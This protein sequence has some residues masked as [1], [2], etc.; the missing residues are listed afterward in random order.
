MSLEGGLVGCQIGVD[1]YK[2]GLLR[3][4]HGKEG[5]LEGTWAAGLQAAQDRNLS[6]TKL[7]V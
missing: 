7:A 5:A 3:F 4:G 1:S 6:P 2:R